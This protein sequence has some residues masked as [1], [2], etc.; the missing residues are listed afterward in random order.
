MSVDAQRGQD[1][2]AAGQQSVLGFAD[3]LLHEGSSWQ[4]WSF[5]N[6]SQTP[7]SPL[8]ATA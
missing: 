8:E 1:G 2:R 7:K 6:I 5:G 4:C 3:V